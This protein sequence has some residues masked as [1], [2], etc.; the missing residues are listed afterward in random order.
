MQRSLIPVVLNY[1][2]IFFYNCVGFLFVFFCF[3]NILVVLGDINTFALQVKL[4]FNFI[5]IGCF[6]FD[7]LKQINHAHSGREQD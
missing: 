5:L 2:T 1:K 3:C 6:L 4:L 7:V